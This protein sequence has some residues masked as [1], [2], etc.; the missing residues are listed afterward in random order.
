L[1]LD[2]TVGGLQ[3]F[4]TTWVAAQPNVV[5]TA[6]KQVIVGEVRLLVPLE[7]LRALPGVFARRPIFRPN[8]SA[9]VL[10]QFTMGVVPWASAA[11][12]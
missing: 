11:T 2:A 12:R 10:D 6:V 1:R 9:R 4:L 7:A 5:F 8:P 3:G